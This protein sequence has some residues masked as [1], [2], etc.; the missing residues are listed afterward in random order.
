MKLLWLISRIIIG[1][2][3]IIIIIITISIQRNIEIIVDRCDIIRSG[4]GD[5]RNIISSTN[6]NQM[7]WSESMSIRFVHIDT[8]K[9]E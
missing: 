7:K 5:R 3:R 6:D 1:V 4:K 2:I 9:P 8:W